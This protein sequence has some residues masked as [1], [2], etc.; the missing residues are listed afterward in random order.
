MYSTFITILLMFSTFVEFLL[1]KIV[2]IFI[3]KMT[4]LNFK[5]SI[6]VPYDPDSINTSFTDVTS[7]AI[8]HN[9]YL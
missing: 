3:V 7:F 4:I 1:F 2:G 5:I 8:D 6:F 9:A